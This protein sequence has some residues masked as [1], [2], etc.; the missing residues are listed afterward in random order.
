MALIETIQLPPYYD[1][2]EYGD[3]DFDPDHALHYLAYSR[4]SGAWFVDREPV[5]W[6]PVDEDHPDDWDPDSPDLHARL[7]R[8]PSFPNGYERKGELRADTVTIDDLQ[9]R[10][11]VDIFSCPPP[12]TPAFWALYQEPVEDILQAGRTLV[13]CQSDSR[14][15][16]D[17]H[18]ISR[19]IYKLMQGTSLVL[20]A[21]GYP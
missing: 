21:E 17:T 2:S 7:V 4:V 11:A 12:D 19:S 15:K 9:H 1:Q 5:L 13:R 20:H 14:Q 6:M 10:L 18:L 16:S 3:I 8:D